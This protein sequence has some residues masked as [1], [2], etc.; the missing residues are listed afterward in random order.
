MKALRKFMV[1]MTSATLVVSAI[2][3]SLFPMTDAY[4]ASN[5]DDN[6]DNKDH[7]RTQDKVKVDCNDI[8]VVLVALRFSADNLSED[9]RDDV[10]AS[11]NEGEVAS[12]L[13][14]ILDH[15]LVDLLRKVQQKCDDEQIQEILDF[16]G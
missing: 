2:A 3:A 4:A 12:D 14:F 1:G 11:L 10:D 5:S 13:Q 6:N 7:S 15:N 9:E 16:V 8:A